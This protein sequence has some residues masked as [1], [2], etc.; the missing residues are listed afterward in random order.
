MAENKVKLV[1]WKAREHGVPQYGYKHHNDS[2]V[3]S[4]PGAFE[5]EVADAQT[6]ICNAMSAAYSYLYR[7]FHPDLVRE[8]IE[9][10]EDQDGYSYWMVHFG[11]AKSDSPHFCR[12]I[13]ELALGDDFLQY[14]DN[15]G[16]RYWHLT[17]PM[18][19]PI[20]S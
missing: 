14:L 20:Q 17:P 7:I 10:A 2:I 15:T 13:D 6:S 3:F 1:E 4:G 18:S 16:V 9:G 11:L 12:G 8:Y 19:S 5:D